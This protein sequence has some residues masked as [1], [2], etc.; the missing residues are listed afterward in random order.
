MRLVQP[1]R[2]RELVI[3]G[4]A[5]LDFIPLV[6]VLALVTF[7]LVPVIRTERG[8]LRERR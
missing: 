2:Q 5:M 4:F 7:L 3:S 1:R 6:S 8:L